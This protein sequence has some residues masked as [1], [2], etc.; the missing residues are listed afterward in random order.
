MITL[1]PVDETN[2]REC[3][4]LSVH[5]SQRNFVASNVFSL[6]QAYVFYEN[7]K[8]VCIYSGDVMVGFAMYGPE[9]E[10]MNID[11]FMIDKAHQGKGLGRAAMASLLSRIRTEY[12]EY[13]EI[14]RAHV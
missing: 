12:P 13:E 4:G 2:Y 3:I 7:A 1:R 6:A 8:P 14:G 5:E 10:R 11:R 9:E